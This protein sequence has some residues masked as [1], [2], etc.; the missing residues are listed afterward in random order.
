MTKLRA[1]GIALAAAGIVVAGSGVAAAAAPAPA[2][3]GAPS[4]QQ[5]ADMYPI[6]KVLLDLVKALSS[7]S[8]DGA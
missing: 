1:F 2:P 3:A 6:D 7:G 8:A 4:A 5:V